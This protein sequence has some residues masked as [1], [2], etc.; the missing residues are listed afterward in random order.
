MTNNEIQNSAAPSPKAFLGGA[1]YCTVASYKHE[2]AKVQAG[3]VRERALRRQR[4]ELIEQLETLSSESS[5]RL[6]NG[7]QMV[8]S[9]LSLQ[10]R[11][12]TNPEV[13]LRLTEAANR[14]AM[15]E[16]VHRHL[17]RF[18]GEP[19]VAFMQYLEVLCREYSAL[20]SSKARSD[21]AIVVEGI[22]VELP[23]ATAIPLGFIVNEMITNATKYGRGRVIVT[24]KPNAEKGYA[25]SVFSDG[26]SL[27]DGF[28]PAACKGLGMK[29]I[30]SLVRQ[31]GGE[32]RF[33]SG[34]TNQGA[35]FT[36]LFS[37]PHTRP[38]INGRAA[39]GGARSSA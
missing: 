38:K 12:S 25:L 15:I 8:V 3:L 6:L 4:D 7:L 29:I 13:A 11:A 14:V 9:L 28:D 35:R 10:I 5:H 18:D 19:T 33:G 36:V 32:L 23:T 20:R 30:L 22:E 31:I 17:H 34:E 37:C 2:L 27:P 24:L 26:P 21:Q 1:R 39:G 16:R